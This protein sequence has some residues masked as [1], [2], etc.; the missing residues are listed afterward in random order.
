MISI[1]FVQSLLLFLLS[2]CVL[3]LYVS[4]KG[5]S[6]DGFQLV[7]F[8]GGFKVVEGVNLANVYR[9]KQNV[10]AKRAEIET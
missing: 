9:W 2:V 5:I 1:Y 6:A 4:T 8:L 3:Y 7:P 10:W